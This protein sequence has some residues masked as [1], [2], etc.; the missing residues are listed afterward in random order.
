MASSQFNLDSC[1]M[2]ITTRSSK[3]FSSKF[4]QAML[5]EGLAKSAWMALYYIHQNDQIN[6]HDLAELI[7][8]TGPSLVKIVSQLAAERLIQ[9]TPSKLDKRERILTLTSTGQQRLTA[10]L[11]VADAFQQQMTAGISQKDLDT[12][13]MVMAKMVANAQRFNP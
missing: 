12:V 6:Q 13:A 4:N 5:P 2:F 7:G 11:P 8:I 1:M 3:L 9:I 10:S